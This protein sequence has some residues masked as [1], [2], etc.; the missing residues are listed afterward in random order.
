LSYRSVVAADAPLHWWRCSD[1]GGSI[2]HDYGSAPQAAWG[3][4]GNTIQR[5]TGIAAD[6][7]SAFFPGNSDMG[8]VD[9][10][11]NW[12]SPM[13]LECWVWQLARFAVKQIP[14]YVGS[15]TAA[16]GLSISAT[17]VPGCSGTVAVNGAV[18][19]PIQSWHHLACTY[20][21][22]N[23]RLYVDGVQVQLGASAVHLSVAA[24]GFL[25]EDV[26]LA[27]RFRGFIAEAAQYATALSAARIA[28]HFAAW[29]VTA[30]PVYTG[31]GAVDITTGGI[32]PDPAQLAALVAYVSRAYQNAV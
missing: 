21:E 11:A 5:F 2:V 13:S 1:P 32:T 18:A 4:A 19:I 30:F 6:G 26:N 8:T 24:P 15:A 20:D 29:E 22:V 28:A 3:Q 12:V 10:L 25:G 27:N 17:G 23:L 16:T 9:N 7:G 14:F 31:A